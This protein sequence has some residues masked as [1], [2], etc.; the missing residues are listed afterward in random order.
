[1]ILILFGMTAG[2]ATGQDSA[3]PASKPKSTDELIDSV[4]AQ[5]ERKAEVVVVTTPNSEQPR[6]KSPDELIDELPVHGVVPSAMSSKVRAAYDDAIERQYRHQIWSMEQRETIFGW[7]HWAGVIVF[8]IA[9][10]VVIAG[11]VMSWLQFRAGL[12]PLRNA[13]APQEDQPNKDMKLPDASDKEEV[14]PA[15]TDTHDEKH[16]PAAGHSVTVTPTSATVST[17]FVGVVIL[18]L[19]LAFFYLYLQFVFPIS[20]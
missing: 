18:T 10:G 2:L 12:R 8:F 15:A 20:K 5:S 4:P 11:L 17:S 14:T 6:A 3:A 19:S 13:A 16:T 1:M 7:Q 9:N